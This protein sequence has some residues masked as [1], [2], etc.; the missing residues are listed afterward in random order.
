VLFY[1]LIDRE[2]T[3]R[4]QQLLIIAQRMGM[5]SEAQ[6]RALLQAAGPATA[7]Q[8]LPLFEM[9]FP[10]L[11]RRPPDYLSRVLETV[12]AL[13]EADGRTDVFEF[14]LARV[15]SQHL[16]ESYNPDRVRLAGSKSLSTCRQEAMQVMAVL[17]RHGHEEN[18]AAETAFRA[19]CA[20]L[21]FDSEATM[22]ATAD[23]SKL[24]DTALSTLDRLKPAEKS[25]LVNALATVVLH[26]QRM[27]AAE[28]ELLRAACDLIHV[29]LPLIAS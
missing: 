23:W 16:W 22:P 1:T 17:A 29:P 24:L 12:K 19:G 10:A 21:G 5:D 4:E 6:V 18:A 26:D 14:L 28:L 13:T 15:I 2:D 27:V 7:N 9:A 25:R 20:T 3:L 8:R 11:K